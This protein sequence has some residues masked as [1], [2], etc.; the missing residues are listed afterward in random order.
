MKG[1]SKRGP[2]ASPQPSVLKLALPD[3]TAQLTS[4]IEAGRELIDTDAANLNT[5]LVRKSRTKYI[6]ADVEEIRAL[7]S[8]AEQWRDYNRTW[9]RKHLGG[10]ALEEYERVAAYFSAHGSS[11]VQALAAL[12]VLVAQEVSKLE[13]IRAR[14]PMWVPEDVV[15]PAGTQ[16]SSRS[17]DSK[18]TAFA[19]NRKAVMVIY[20]HDTQA[21]AALFDWLRSIGLQPQEWSQIMAASGSASPYIG[22]ALERTLKNVQAVVAFF[23]PD[24]RVLATNA[25]PD[26]PN[27]WRLQARPKVLIEAGMA[28]ST[29]PTRTVLVVLGPQELPTDLAGRHYVRLTNTAEPLHDLASRLQQ[30]GCDIDTRGTSWLDPARFPDR[31]H[32]PPV[33]PAG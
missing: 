14:L 24:E 30:A 20:G 33:P 8:Q 18:A 5:Q 13:S 4:R 25:S 10:E 9:L 16:S 19:T 32:V 26:N 29:H 23:T 2:S 31:S 12:C 1:V 21:N 3:A 27:A 22:Q 15:T 28:L 11:A 6:S 7:R 17:G